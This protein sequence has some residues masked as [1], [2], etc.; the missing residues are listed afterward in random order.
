MHT[1]TPWKGKNILFHH[2]A[3]ELGSMGMLCTGSET[4][5]AEAKANFAEMIRRVDSHDALVEALNRVQGELIYMAEKLP[6]TNAKQALAQ[7]RA[8]LSHARPRGE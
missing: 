8:A 4:A 3:E 6:Y 7:V 5:I 1:P 2:G